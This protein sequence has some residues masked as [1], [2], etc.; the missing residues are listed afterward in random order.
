MSVV[1]ALDAKRDR[2]LVLDGDNRNPLPFWV[3]VAAL[4]DAMATVDDITGEMRNYL[5]IRV[6]LR[7]AEIIVVG[8]RGLGGGCRWFVVY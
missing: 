2:V 1:A 3:S 8:F 5:L 6:R 7:R 4:V